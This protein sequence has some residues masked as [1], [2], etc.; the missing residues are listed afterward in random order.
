MIAKYGLPKTTLAKA[1]QAKPVFGT[2]PE[3][4]IWPRGRVFGNKTDFASGA[5]SVGNLK[6]ESLGRIN[7]RRF[8]CM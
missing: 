1:W 7:A 5:R 3:T 6:K 2:V 8:R 4:V